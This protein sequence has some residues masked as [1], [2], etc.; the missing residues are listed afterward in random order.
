M[1]FKIYKSEYNPSNLTGLV[2]GSISTQTL[3][4]YINELFYHV[5][6]PPSGIDVTAYQYRKVFIKN[7]HSS[8]STNTR[9]WIDSAEHE[10]QISLCNSDT[11]SD[12][13]TSPTGE[14]TNVTGWIS[15]SNYAEGLSLG[16]LSANGSTGVWIRQAL[17]DISSPDPYATFRLYA[18]GLL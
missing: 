4:G 10:D 7:E 6:S 16:T 12:L 3:S 5:T 8:S 9:V 15:P 14:P 1:T 2:G 18:G 11:Y 17:S 13:S